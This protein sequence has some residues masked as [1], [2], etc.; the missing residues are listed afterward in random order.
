MKL[1]L[2]DD[3]KELVQ[4]LQEELSKYFI[5]EIAHNGKQG[6]YLAHIN[7]YDIIILDIVLPD[8]DGIEIC[9]MLRKAKI[10][11]PIIILTGKLDHSTKVA[12]LNIGAD[13]YITKP[14]H[15]PEL[16]S[17][18]RAVLR[19][20]KNVFNANVLTIADLQIDFDTKQVIRN[21][22][23]I[24]LRKK[25]FYLLE[26]LARNVGSVITRDMILN[27]VWE[28]DTDALTNIVD[29]H[30]KY[31]RDQIDKDFNKKLIKTVHGIGY[32]LEA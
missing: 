20:Q 16:L 6:E 27:H 22:K 32:K 12:T 5:V 11:T 13:D 18:I 2:I 7:D 25:E 9:R 4:T 30:I 31:L 1:L 3:N 15:L 17:R 21:N 29:V 8:I 28:S 24:S 19:R 23:I 10:H 14:F 26:Y